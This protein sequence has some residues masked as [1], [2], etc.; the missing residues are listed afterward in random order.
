MSLYHL[1]SGVNVL[2]V[3]DLADQREVVAVML[4]ELGARVVTV[5]TAQE[6]LDALERARPDVL[7]SDLM[8]PGLDGIG[9]I[10]RVRALRP[11]RGGDTPAAAITAHGIRASDALAAGFQAFATKPIDIAELAVIV[12]ALARRSHA[13]EHGWTKEARVLAAAREYASVRRLDAPTSVAVVGVPVP[14]EGGREV[15]Q[16]RLRTVNRSFVV[17][18]LVSANGIVESLYDTTDR[19]LCA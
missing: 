7:L 19:R 2:V 1:L 3:D 12:S 6:G 5:S 15:W 16:V 14:L 11:E 13:E 9:F 18:A 8:M 10:E 4:E 17:R